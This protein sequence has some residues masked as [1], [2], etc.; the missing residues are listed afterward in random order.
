MSQKGCLWLLFA[1]LMVPLATAGCIGSDAVENSFEDA[2]SRY[3]NSYAG[4]H[5]RTH[6]FDVSETVQQLRVA[7]HYDVSGGFTVQ[8]MSPSGMVDQLNEG[9][10][11]EQ[12]D[13]AWYTKSDPAAGEWKLQVSGGGSGSY[14]FGVYRE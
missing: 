6:T 10:A 1:G 11:G 14:A 2:D 4:G 12:K 8:L 3:I 9:G 13:D 5:Q 7:L